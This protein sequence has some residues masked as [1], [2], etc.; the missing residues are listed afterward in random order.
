MSMTVK[1]VKLSDLS[2]STFNPSTRTLKVAGLVRSIQE[3]GLLMPILIT[4]QNRIIDGH[5]RV[6]AYDKMEL[7]E[8]PAIV[9]EGEP[10]ALFAH[11][12]SQAKKLSGNESLEVFLKEP[13]AVIPLIRA[14]FLEAEENLGRQL[15]ERLSNEG[16]SLNTYRVAVRLAEEADKVTPDVLKKITRWMLKHGATGVLRK[17]MDAGTPPGLLMTAVER[18]KPIRSQFAIGKPRRKRV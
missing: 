11:A 8:I 1:I 7:K 14:R 16:L 13:N 12:N 4:K 18:D 6:A 2:K 10:A 5:R 15:L 17:A 3:V 9:V